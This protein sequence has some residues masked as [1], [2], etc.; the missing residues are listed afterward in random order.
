MHIY[1]LQWAFSGCA[2]CDWVEQQQQHNL[3]VEE[4]EKVSSEMPAVPS[5][6]ADLPPEET[7]AVETVTSSQ[8]KGSPKILRLQN[9]T[10][11]F[12][13]SFC[14]QILQIIM[15][16][17]SRPKKCPYTRTCRIQTLTVSILFHQPDHWPV[18]LC[19]FPQEMPAVLLACLNALITLDAY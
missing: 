17:I 8:M 1:P 10:L 9:F 19:P 5:L 14:S 18:A 15:F 7:V 13:E 12:Q 11:L 6:F 16:V 3:N 2:L 4:P